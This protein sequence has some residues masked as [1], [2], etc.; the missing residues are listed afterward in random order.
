MTDIVYGPFI[1]CLSYSVWVMLIFDGRTMTCRCLL[2]RHLDR[3]L[4]N[5]RPNNIFL[6]VY[7]ARGLFISNYEFAP[8]LEKSY[9]QEHITSRLQIRP[10]YYY[11]HDKYM[12]SR[13][14]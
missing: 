2:L 5:W 12:F 3:K 10:Q 14:K 11:Q 7:K 9:L 4:A 8:D 13:Q 6:F 1:Y